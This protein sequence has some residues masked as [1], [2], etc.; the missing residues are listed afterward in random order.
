MKPPLIAYLIALGAGL[1]YALRSLG[2]G[3]E[4]SDPDEKK[5]RT[6]QR[7][8]IDLELPQA[9]TFE[10]SLWKEASARRLAAELERLGFRTVTEGPGVDGEWSCLAVREVRVELATFRE[11][12]GRFKE[13]VE[14]EGGAYEGWE[15]GDASSDEAPAA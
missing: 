2:A 11:L 6:L 12:R 14:I 15:L 9:V 13:L 1:F 10:V 3:R 4:P 8:E 7:L 5:I